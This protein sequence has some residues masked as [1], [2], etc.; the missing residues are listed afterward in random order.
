MKNADN[1]FGNTIM[2]FDKMS[3]YSCIK[4]FHEHNYFQFKPRSERLKEI[5]TDPFILSLIPEM[6]VLYSHNIIPIGTMGF[7]KF[8]EEYMLDAGLHIQEMYRKQGYSHLLMKEVLKY[9]SNHKY[10]VPIVNPDIVNF[11]KEYEFQ[12]FTLNIL[13]LTLRN[14]YQKYKDEGHAVLIRYP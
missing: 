13:P 2:Y 3:E 8:D 1:T 4:S 5:V 9:Q 10:I 12:E 14:Y 11:F 7:I 6:I